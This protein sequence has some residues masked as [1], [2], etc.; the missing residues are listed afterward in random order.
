MS[1]TYPDANS[2]SAQLFERARAV[3]PA[4]NSRL[5]VYHAPYPIYLERAEGCRVTDVE[6]VTRIDCVNNMTALI[7]GHRPPKVMAA[8]RDQMNRMLAAGS[9][10]P[11]EIQLA[12]ILCARLPGVDQIRFANSGTEAVMFAIRAARAFT[13]RAKVAKA[14]GAY[15]G[16]Y[17]PMASGVLAREPLWGDA[18]APTTVPDGLGLS[19]AALSEVV[20]FPFND[21]E[22]TRT[23]LCKHGSELA[24]VVLDLAPSRMRFVEADRDFVR[25]IRQVCDEQGIVLIVDEVMSFRLH[26]G[27]SQTLWDITPDLTAL[28]KIIGGGFPVGAIGGSREIMAVFDHLSG[29]EFVLHGGTYNANPIT[30]TAGAA[31]LEQWTEAEVTRLNSLGERLREG[32]RREL[33]ASNVPGLV[34]GLGSLCFIGLGESGRP[35]RDMRDFASRAFDS[36]LNGRFFRAMLN[37]GVMHSEGGTFILSTAMDENTIDEILDATKASLT[38]LDS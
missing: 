8:V 9:P 6:G 24:A 27:G 1:A 7:H 30:M 28:G 2:K 17:D 18:A 5:T 23:L 34:Q 11:S 38:T 3:M 26:F 31:T 19:P 25:M 33:R 32:F 14:E 16:A 29:G 15:N 10:T 36:A 12:E 35:I 4:G 21:I 13:G 22:N 20:T 37:H